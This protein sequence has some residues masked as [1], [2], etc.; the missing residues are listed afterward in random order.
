MKPI[1]MNDNQ[2]VYA[3]QGQGEPALQRR[4]LREP[5][6]V[7]SDLH[8]NR[9]DSWKERLDELRPLWAG[10][11][12]VVFNGDTL[13]WFTATD[14]PKS[15][16]I[17]DYLRRLC[18]ED[19]TRPMLLAGNSDNSIVPDRHVFLGGGGVLVTHGDVLFPGISPWRARSKDLLAIRRRVLR[20]MTASRRATLE[21]QLAS[22]SRTMST[23]RQETLEG[24]E[25]LSELREAPW[26]RENP[27]GL[28]ALLR[29]WWVTPKMA[30][31]FLA[32][33][34][35]QASVI[36]IG[37]THRSG[38]WERDGR[39]VINTGSFARA[40][41]PLT[42]WVS[43]DTLTARTV[44]KDSSGLRPGKALTSF[45]VTHADWRAPVQVHVEATYEGGTTT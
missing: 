5:V 6:V 22:A 21:G 1:G 3:S 17:L 35:P 33:F 45:K 12:T 30:V 36:V 15:E 10:A 26:W 43:G 4:V 19:G 8:L 39:T 18:E 2:G 34:A 20:E 32:E 44:I 11:A 40:A 27:A 23:L 31:R 16:E 14:T 28:V 41:K 25:D 7:L 24:I 37:H 29:T 42:V 9:S 38:V 13:D